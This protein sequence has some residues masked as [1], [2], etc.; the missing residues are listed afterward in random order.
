MGHAY[1]LACCSWK[2]EHHVPL[3]EMQRWAAGS[4]SVRMNDLRLVSCSSAV[5]RVAEASRICSER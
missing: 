4:S 5:A 3:V 1:D 2:S